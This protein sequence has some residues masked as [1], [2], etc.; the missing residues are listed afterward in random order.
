MRSIV[1]LRSLCAGLVASLVAVA[2]TAAPAAADDAGALYKQGI[3]WKN[4]GKDDEAI[5][6]FEKAL[7]ADPNDVELLLALSMAHSKAGDQDKAIEIS[8]RAAEIDPTD[9]FPHTNLSMFYQKKGMTEVAE[10]HSA[11]VTQL[12]IEAQKRAQGA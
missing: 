7:T 3:S 4:Q 12:N 9:P 1:S 10:Q 5:A 6:A 11:M 8:L 2:F